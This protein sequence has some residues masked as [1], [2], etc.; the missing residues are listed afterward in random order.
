MLGNLQSDETGDG[1]DSPLLPAPVESGAI[2]PLL[3][4]APARELGWAGAPVI[5]V[6]ND[7]AGACRALAWEQV[8]A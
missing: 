8:I 5:L 3:L 7:V 4:G 6:T 2:D 1:E